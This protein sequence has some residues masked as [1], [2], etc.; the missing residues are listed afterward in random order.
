MADTVISPIV[1]S[2]AFVIGQAYTL[3][4]TCCCL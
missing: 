1:D 3:G 2:Q 4:L